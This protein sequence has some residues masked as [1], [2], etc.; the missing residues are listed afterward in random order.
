MPND[1]HASV[2]F[3]NLAIFL[4]TAS[5]LKH[6]ALSFQGRKK[7]DISPLLASFVSLQKEGLEGF[8]EWEKLVLEGISC[9]ESELGGLLVGQGK[10]REVRLG[11]EGVR[12]AHQLVNGGV[13]LREGCWRGLVAMVGLQVALEGR[14]DLVGLESG[15]CWV[16]EGVVDLR[17][18]IVGGR[19]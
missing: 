2:A 14:G 1:L 11:G 17:A 5:L 12:S 7:V 3:N 9:T 10:L 13:C 18:L 6:F 15:E 8:R 16:L 4:H 19:G